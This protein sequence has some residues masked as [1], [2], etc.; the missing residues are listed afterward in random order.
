[1]VG[2]LPA[3]ARDRPAAD[4][5]LHR[6]PDPD[7]RVRPDPPGHRGRRCGHG[8]DPRVLR[9]Q[10]RPAARPRRPGAAARGGP[11]GSGSPGNTP[12]GLTVVRHG[13]DRVTTRR[14]GRW[15]TEG[16]RWPTR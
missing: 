16:T 4:P 5:G 2:V 7:R 10:A 3:R 15:T 6:R 13:V 1:E 8:P 11:R 14:P 9:R 12:E